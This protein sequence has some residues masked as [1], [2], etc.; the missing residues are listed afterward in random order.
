M[1]DAYV[2]AGGVKAIAVTLTV[3]SAMQA[4]GMDKHWYDLL[5][6]AGGALVGLVIDCDLDIDAGTLSLHQ[7]ERA[8][9][10]G[11]L[12]GHFFALYWKPYA[13]AIHHR[14]LVSH[15]PVFST[16]IR[17]LYLLPLTLLS[18]YLGQLAAFYWL[19]FSLWDLLVKFKSEAFW[20]GIRA[21]IGLILADT[22]HFALDWAHSQY[23]KGNR[24]EH[25]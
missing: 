6:M 4:I 16:L 21:I 5:P 19:H 12:L 8:A 15:A 9:L 17:L 23:G 13:L 7:L 10:P 11:W 14:S 18:I 1:P 20:F 2:H 25:Y 22:T 24:D 3:V